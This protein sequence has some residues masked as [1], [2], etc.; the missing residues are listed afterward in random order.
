MSQFDLSLAQL[1]PSLSFD[2]Y[3]KGLRQ[4][5]A[6]LKF[7][8]GTPCL[9]PLKTWSFQIFKSDHTRPP[10][11]QCF[12]CI[13]NYNYQNKDVCKKLE[14]KTLKFDQTTDIL[15]IS[16]ISQKFDFSSVFKKMAPTPNV[17]MLYLSLWRASW[18]F[19]SI[20]KIKK[21]S[22]VI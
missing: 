22:P 21:Y 5:W 20:N 14:L 18:L 15:V 11:T 17:L 1:S 10:I 13:I 9:G 8:G 6:N 4:V 7:L 19:W 2:F 3:F 16:E 12:L